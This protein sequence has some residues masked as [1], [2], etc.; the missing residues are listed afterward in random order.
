MSERRRL[1]VCYFGGYRPEYPRHKFYANALQALEVDVVECQVSHKLPTLARIGA[2]ALEFFR[3]KCWADVIYVEEFNHSLIPFAWVIARLT[4]QALVFDPGVSPYDELVLNAKQ[5]APGSWYAKYLWANN[6]LSFRLPDLVIWFTPIDM[7]YF[8]QMFGIAP[9]RCAWLA[10]GVD[11]TVFNLIPM[12]P[13]RR[14]LVVHFDGNMSPTHGIDVMLRAAAL[15]P[16]ED[17]RF[18]I[19]GAGMVAEMRALARELKLTNVNIPGFVSREELQASMCRAHICLGAFRED[20]KLRRTL[21]TKELQAMLC[22]RPVVTGYGEAKALLF[23]DGDDLVMVPPED[24][25]SLAASLMALRD[26]PGR[27]QAVALNAY[28]ASRALLAPENTGQKLLKL[29]THAAN[30][31]RGVVGQKPGPPL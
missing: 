11:L 16:A 29:L 1:K 10:P 14:P 18:E 12:P 22:G 13:V 24:P 4:G 21:Y 9:E 17:F 26:N 28:R 8:R 5:V 23:R 7:D 31:R 15:L 20:G 2:L 19:I 6:W 30:Q 25:N 3:K 27:M